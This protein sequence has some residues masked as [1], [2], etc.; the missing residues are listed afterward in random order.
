MITKKIQYQVT[1]LNCEGFLA[2]NN[3]D[4]LK[5]LV[6]IVHAFEG[7]NQFV[8]DYAKKI[9]E[10]GYIGFAIDMYGNGT[11]A[12]TFE[13]CLKLYSVLAND[14]PLIRQR[15][16]ETLE[17]S[18]TLDHVDTNQTAAIGFCFGGMCCLD[19]ARSGANINGVVSF[20]GSLDKPNDLKNNPITAKILAMHGYKDPQIPYEHIKSFMDEMQQVDLQFVIYNQAK[21]AFTD[22]NASQIGP[23][24]VGREYNQLAA[25][26]SWLECKKFLTEIF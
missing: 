12:N 9:A 13:D 11:V 10:L 24:E 20:H 5:P 17:F 1:N 15:M 18:K 25:E 14:R 3:D 23:P 4:K 22:P 2:Y 6:V 7:C 26:R 21:H 8:K 19:L 16:I